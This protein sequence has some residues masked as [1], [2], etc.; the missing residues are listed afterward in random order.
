MATEST[1]PVHRITCGA[2]SCAIWLRNGRD[3]TFYAAT[4]QRWYTKDG[5]DEYTSSFVRG[6]LLEVAKLFDLAHTWIVAKESGA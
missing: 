6:D 4:V 5:K 3:G 1:K 2:L